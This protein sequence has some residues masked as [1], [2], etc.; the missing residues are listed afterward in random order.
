MLLN[1]EVA[2]LIADELD[3]PCPKFGGQRTLCDGFRAPDGAA[4]SSD[5]VNVASLVGLPAGALHANFWLVPDE[6][7]DDFA[8][9]LADLW[10]AQDGHVALVGLWCSPKAVPGPHGHHVVGCVAGG[11]APRLGRRPPEAFT[12]LFDAGL[13]Q[14]VLAS[15]NEDQWIFS[16]AIPLCAPL[17]TPEADTALIEAQLST[18]LSACASCER[19]DVV[20]ALND[21]L[22][23]AHDHHRA[24]IDAFIAQE[25]HALKG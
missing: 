6:T 24:W 10:A 2:A 23:E 9:R 8:D 13:G 22:Q 20:V 21:H 1:V 7:A 25:R 5:D 17:F 11:S 15:D 16:L 12:K 4:L 14:I 19:E 18:L 3:K